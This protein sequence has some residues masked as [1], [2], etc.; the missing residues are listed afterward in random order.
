MGVCWLSVAFLITLSSV[1]LLHG[2]LPN[3][4]SSTPSV[5]N[6]T[7]R[8]PAGAILSAS[9]AADA[10]S[11]KQVP[12]LNWSLVMPPIVLLSKP[13]SVVKPDIGGICCVN[14][15]MEMLVPSGAPFIAANAAS[16]NLGALL[17]I[18]LLL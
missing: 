12:P 1:A 14:R 10:A 18:L 11:Y 16:R 6:T 9:T 17:C 15:K 4:S 8:R 2:F 13:L 3:W 7:A 5:N